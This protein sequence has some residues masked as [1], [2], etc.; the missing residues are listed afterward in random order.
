MGVYRSAHDKDKRKSPKKG[1]KKG[2][3]AKYDDR[4]N[5]EKA[6]KELKE[7]MRNVGKAQKRKL[8]DAKANKSDEKGRAKKGLNKGNEIIGKAD[9]GEGKALKSTD[10]SDQEGLKNIEKASEGKLEDAKTDK[11]DKKGQDKEELNK[12]NEIIG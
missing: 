2:R 9:E 3:T 1:S 4:S 10:N 7:R 12:G 11:S 5:K 6:D 8:E